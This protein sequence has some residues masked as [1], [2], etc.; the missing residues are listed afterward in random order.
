[1][2]FDGFLKIWTHALF[3]FT[4][5]KVDLRVEDVHL[6]VLDLKPKIGQM[7]LKGPL[8]AQNEERRSFNWAK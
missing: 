8:G 4:G 7:G 6:P 3:R 5:P 1:M 2:V